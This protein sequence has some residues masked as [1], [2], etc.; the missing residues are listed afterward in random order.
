MHP[1]AP[2]TILQNRYRLIRVLGQGGFA[3]TYLAEDRGR[4][5]EQCVL[6]EFIPSQ[7][8]T[9]MLEKSRALFQREAE[10]LYQIQHPQIPQ[11]RASFEYDNP[12][13]ARLFLVQDYV[14]G[15]TYRS[16]LHDRKAKGHT[17]S[18]AEVQTLLHQLLPV[19]DHLHTQGMIHR[20]ISLENLIL[21][22][23][24]QC[25]VLIDFGVVKT[26]VT[27][28]YSDENTPG[29]VVGKLGFA[30]FEQIQTG[31][32]YPSSDLYA[33][34]VC[35]LVLLTGR[36]PQS[37]FQDAS[38][39]W[40]WRPYAQVSPAFAQVLERMIAYRP[41]DRYQ[42]A[43]DVIKALQ[44]LPDPIQQPATLDA[45]LDPG[46]PS[47]E[48]ALSQMGTI[49]VDGP[50]RLQMPRQRPAV[51]PPVHHQPRR[52][53]WERPW[54]P[55]VLGVILAIGAILAGWTLTRLLIEAQRQRPPQVPVA[56]PEPSPPPSP[57]N[58]S[59]FLSLE[60]GEQVVVEGELAPGEVHIYR[61]AA[62][63]G[64]ELTTR[65]SGEGVR[66]VLLDSNRRPLRR[67]RDV[68][69][70]Q[71]RLPNRG[72]Y[73][74]QLQLATSITTAR[75]FR[76]TVDLVDPQP[77]PDPIPLPIPGPEVPDPVEPE[78][79]VE[80]IQLTASEGSQQ[81]SG[82]IRANQIKRYQ[83]PIAPGQQFA[84]SVTEGSVTLNLQDQQ[85]NAIPTGQ[86]VLQWTAPNPAEGADSYTVDVV[87]I[88]NTSYGLTLSRPT[89]AIPESGSEAA[90]PEL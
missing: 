82:Q 68:T 9:V 27:Q 14:E 90:E 78:P 89:L 32:A 16:L 8:Q 76:L 47:A 10:I 30:P 12:E 70:W 38:A 85:G 18:E 22:Q 29:T 51:I 59:R 81:I 49:A 31:R 4:F 23:A 43:Q 77:R 67:A 46:D 6:K 88:D 35:A 69:A 56:E 2:D 1:L 80:V 61:L 37:L 40:H 62:E 36:E 53:L 33:L 50:N 66:M 13:G 25:P 44:N 5:Q 83:V 39:T 64:Q 52:S 55:I 48:S 3:R 65:L 87:A 26:V 17:F 60:A 42:S 86:R 57:V 11:F 74:I 54:V 84:V 34:G 58:V 28:L 15:S 21:R 45:G 19:L 24:D 20:D 63:A 7:A 73:L 72:E 79:E 41:G 71:G 75:P